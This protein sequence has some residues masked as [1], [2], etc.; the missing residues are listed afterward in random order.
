M[1]LIK[2]KNK[3]FL[4][5]ITLILIGI[6]FA[7]YNYF[8]YKSVFDHDVEFS[9]GLAI[10]IDINKNFNNSDIEKIVKEVTEESAPQ[11]QRVLNTN[12]VII[13]TKS[14]SEEKRNALINK[15][16]DKY[17][18]DKN[19]SVNISDVS[20]TISKEMKKTAI[21]SIVLACVSILIYVSLRFKNFKIGT[22]AIIAL[23]HDALITIIVYI[24]FRIP[25]NYSFIA[26]ILTILGYSINDTIVIFDRIRENKLSIAIKNN[27][28]LI[29]TSVSQTFSRSIFTSVSTLLSIICLYLIGSPSIKDFSLPIIIGIICGT[30]SSVCIAPSIWFLMSSKK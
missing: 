19:K 23:F 28:D 13:K 29:N 27:T 14:L 8:N 12:Q 1:N 11:V 16:A 2:N 15:L 20:A 26:V 3:F 6:I 17:N 9:G 4:I 30:Y 18:F 25:L 21:I 24:V 10:R 22:S 7:V 5:S